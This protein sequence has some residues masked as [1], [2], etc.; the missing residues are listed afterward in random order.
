MRASIRPTRSSHS[1]AIRARIASSPARGRPIRSS[2]PRS[3]AS[4]SDC[5]VA[6]AS[7]SSAL[8]IQ[9]AIPRLSSPASRTWSTSTLGSGASSSLAPSTPSNRA[10]V[11]STE[12]VVLPSISAATCPAIRSAAARQEAITPGSR[13]SLDLTRGSFLSVAPMSTQ[14]K[15]GKRTRGNALAYYVR[16]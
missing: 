1:R 7:A 16:E 3:T 13:S 15:Q 14:G 10:T 5:G 2:S 11:R 12:T 4:V 9:Y 6:A 8:P